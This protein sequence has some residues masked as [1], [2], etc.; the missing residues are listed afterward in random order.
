VVISIIFLLF[1]GNLSSPH[2]NQIYQSLTSRIS[3][4]DYNYYSRLPLFYDIIAVTPSLCR[5]NA[6]S[7]NSK[8]RQSPIFTFVI[9]LY[10]L[11]SS[12]IWS[13]TLDTLGWLWSVDMSSY[14]SADAIS[15]KH[16]SVLV[17]ALMEIP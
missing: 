16:W 9:C 4:T 7:N 3:T 2:C 15:C 6:C 1:C 8:T 12:D 13:A 17:Q 11:M 10:F 14:V 5:I